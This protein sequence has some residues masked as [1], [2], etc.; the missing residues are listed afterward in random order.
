MTPV[1]YL[2]ENACGGFLF[3]DDSPFTTHIFN[4]L[5]EAVESFGH[6]IVCP[7]S[8][9]ERT[10]AGYND[11]LGG[12]EYRPRTTV[13]DGAPRTLTVTERSEY[14]RG[15]IHGLQQG[16]GMQTTT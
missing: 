13:S 4:T 9:S 10:H 11:A 15:Y 16:A 2:G 8:T 12:L 14:A 5:A 6:R 3:G 7:A 1:L